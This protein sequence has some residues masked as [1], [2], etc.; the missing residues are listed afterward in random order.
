VKDMEDDLEHE[1]KVYVKGIN[2]DQEESLRF[3]LEAVKTYANFHFGSQLDDD[4]LNRGL[5]DRIANL[6]KDSDGGI[7]AIYF[8]DENN[9]IINPDDKNSARVNK[10]LVAQGK[11]G[12]SEGG[13]KE[14]SLTLMLN[15]LTTAINSANREYRNGGTDSAYSVTEAKIRELLVNNP[16]VFEDG[17]QVFLVYA[18]KKNSQLQISNWHGLIDSMMTNLSSKF[19]FEAEN[20]DDVFV[21]SKVLTAMRNYLVTNVPD[22]PESVE[23]KVEIASYVS[24]PS[25]IAEGYNVM[26]YAKNYTDMLEDP[27]KSGEINE[28]LFLPGLFIRANQNSHERRGCAVRGYF[29]FSPTRCVPKV[30]R[31]CYFVSAQT[32]K[33]KGQIRV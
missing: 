32:N 13:F 1:V 21:T 5:T 9:E 18:S 30:V 31:T 24:F 15:G 7:D 22:I 20:Q 16:S 4:D 2:D 11:S 23:L 19:Y 33:N 10:I 29:L 12:K 17:A 3:L 14:R 8:L 28:G 26:V 27:E 25:K 6:P